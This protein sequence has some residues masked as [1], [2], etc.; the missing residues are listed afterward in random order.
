MSWVGFTDEELKRLKQQHGDE[1]EPATTVPN[2]KR[3][4][5]NSRTG[6]KQRPRGKI[7]PR[8]TESAKVGSGECG[9]EKKTMSTIE[10]HGTGKVEEERETSSPEC[11]K[12]ESEE[13]GRLEKT[14]SSLRERCP[15]PWKGK[16]QES[17][18]ETIDYSGSNLASAETDVRVIDEPER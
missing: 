10:S 12:S 13:R 17:N 11:E 2:V 1:R 9:E 8:N 15:A 7:R 4:A 5:M 14:K 3:A 16:P 6:K 18:Q